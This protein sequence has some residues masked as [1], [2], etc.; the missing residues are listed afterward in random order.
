MTE[1]PNYK[2]LAQCLNDE[3]K[4]NGC[5]SR[6]G[7]LAS[8]LWNCNPHSEIGEEILTELM[9]LEEGSEFERPLVE[10]FSLIERLALEG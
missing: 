5:V 1:L 10:V 6:V 2:Y 3:L 8:D 4:Q 7:Q 9:L